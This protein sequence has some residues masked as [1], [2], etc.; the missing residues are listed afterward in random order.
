MK[1][2]CPICNHRTEKLFYAGYQPTSLVDLCD[3]A[4]E[5]MGLYVYPMN[6][7]ICK[8]CMHVCNI[9]YH[10]DFA[11]YTNGCHMYNDGLKWQQHVNNVKK[12]IEESYEGI[13]AILEIGAGDCSF[14]KS[15]NI[16]ADL[17]A[18]DPSEEVKQSNIKYKKKMFEPE[19]IPEEKSILIIMRHLL[20]HMQDPRGFI[21]DILE[22]VR[23]RNQEAYL[24]IEVP[25]CEEAIEATR[26]EDWTYEHPQNFTHKSLKVLTDLIGSSEISFEYGDEVLLATSQVGTSSFE[27]Q[28]DH[29]IDKYKKIELGMVKAGDWMK[30]N[31]IVFWGGAGK[32]AMFLRRFGAP[33]DAIVV[34]SDSNKWG[35]FVPRTRIQIKDPDILFSMEPKHIVVTTSWRASDIYQE[36]K[37]RRLPFIDVLK[38]EEGELKVVNG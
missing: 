2:R 25:C 23:E 7:Y 13:D 28:V 1:P 19:D 24:L 29:I 11:S 17:Y 20:E 30:E 38:F 35:L 31:D 26:I 37:V 4:L 10:P 16:N 3:T 8:N 36:I 33:D 5:S 14:L 6:M 18:V 9:T 22:V 27:R 12:I 32:S 21:E 15:L 34:D